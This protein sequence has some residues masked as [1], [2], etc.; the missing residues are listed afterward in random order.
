MLEICALAAAGMVMSGDLEAAAGR[1]SL[2]LD[3]AEAARLREDIRT[4]PWKRDLYAGEELVSPLWR[5]IATPGRD[6]RR[7]LER[8]IVIP[9]RGGHFHH[10]FCECG[11]VLT[12]PEDLQPSP[13]GYAC[14]GCGKVHRGERYDA[15]VRRELH[16]ALSRAA[17]NLGIAWQVER[18][19]RFAKKAAEILREYSRAYPG[20]HTG[21]LEGG[22]IYQSL[23]ESMWV[24][25]L[26]A[27]YDLILDSGALDAADRAAVEERLLRPCAKGLTAC[28]IDGNWGSWH[29]S[30]AGVVGYTIRDPELIAFALRS[31]RSQLAEQLGDDGLWPESVHTYHFFPLQAFLYLA[32]AA[33]HSGEDL[34]RLE[35]RPGKGLRAMFRAPLEYAYPDLRLAAINNGWWEAWLP[36]QFYELAWLRYRDEAFRWVLEQ[37]AKAAGRSGLWALLFGE[38]LPGDARPPRLKSKDFPVLGIAVLRGPDSVMTFDYGP[39]LG[40]GQL[41]KMGITLHARGRL[42]AADYGTPGYGSQIL[43]WYT[44]TASHNTVMVD[45]SD[46]KPTDERRLTLFSG[47]PRLEAAAAETAQAYPGVL[48]RRT[49]VR[50]GDDYILVDDLQSEEPRVYDW[51]FRSEGDLSVRRGRLPAAAEFALEHVTVEDSFRAAGSASLAWRQGS[52]ELRLHVFCDDDADVF[53]A[54][55]PA[56]TAARQVRMVAV[57]R[58]GMRARFV[59]ALTPAGSGE[60]V[61]VSLD[62]GTVR[63]RRGDVEDVIALT[64]V[65]DA[66]LES[67]ARFSLVRLVSGRP[68]LAAFVKG[69]ALR[70]KDRVLIEG[71]QRD[72]AQKTVPPEPRAVPQVEG[73]PAQ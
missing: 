45:G 67:D 39:F 33:R 51:L 41:D 71:A 16:M 73:V 65:K 66:E 62:A 64:P 17:L 18:D 11:S 36:G 3:S 68:A 49:V 14:T 26:A 42:W 35:A 20:P 58:A 46:Q 28:G 21:T 43:K 24:I 34:Y 37:R 61:A 23:C 6:A 44:G 1:P 40:H 70:W 10:F 30:A 5:R 69:S 53:L 29:L 47:G 9:A 59:A 13:D 54:R 12:W 56:E 2:F 38:E 55:C 8:E 25:P 19:L 63:I 31:F 4:L 7:W 50:S 32:E 27:A 60:D 52:Q 57:R 48:H 22:M 15:A 72:W